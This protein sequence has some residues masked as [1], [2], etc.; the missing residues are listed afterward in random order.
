VILAAVIA[1]GL[2]SRRFPAMQPRVVATY[3]G[4]VLW[5]VMVFWG[6][7]LLWPRART[8]SL[9]VSAFGVALV[10]EGSQL[11]HTPW[12]VALRETRLGALALGQ[13]FLWSDLACY[14]VGT[15]AAAL[16]D[17]QSRRRPALDS[18]A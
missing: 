6:L 13:G 1:A 8:R 15:S 14:L 3:A 4:D 5:A 2:L 7:A 9:A 11:L 10:V 12:L 17:A 18:S 16:L